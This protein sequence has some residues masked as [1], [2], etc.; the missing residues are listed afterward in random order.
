MDVLLFKALILCYD[1]HIFT[2]L[3]SI[4]LPLF[5]TWIHLHKTYVS[6]NIKQKKWEGNLHKK[7]QKKEHI[8]CY[9]R[10]YVQ[11]K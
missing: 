7:I 5:I 2:V 4:M 8:L 10:S 6:N 3:C 9:V 11:L 1:W